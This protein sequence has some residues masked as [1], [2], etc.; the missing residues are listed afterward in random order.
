M[1]PHSRVLLKR[2]V[3]HGRLVR[4]VYITRDSLLKKAVVVKEHV[5]KADARREARVMQACDDSPH[6]VRF[7]RLIE[8]RGRGLIVMERI[9]GIPLKMMIWRRR[10]FR[11]AD[12][13]K[14][15]RG[16]L[17]G[18]DVLHRS[19]YV[20][21]DLQSANVLVHPRTLRPKL[22]DMQLA[23]RKDAFGKAFSIRKRARP[24]RY[25]PEGIGPVIDDS[26]DIYSV[27]YMC[28]C[29][30]LRRE[31]RSVRRPAR[32]SRSIARLWDV[33][34]KAMRRE[35]AERYPSARAMMKALKGLTAKR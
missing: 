1:S 17:S 30:L 13:V 12:V 21:G 31:V 20:H 8:R 24:P 33:I 25:A 23:V 6:L 18:L 4:L 34:V 16:I 15:T 3:K 9:R 14:I 35:P 10:R 27:G 11:P 2:K 32:A 7:H 29:M 5:D 28:A 19:G 22:I 26:F